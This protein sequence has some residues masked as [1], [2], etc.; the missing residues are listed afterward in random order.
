[1]PTRRI[2]DPRW[3]GADPAHTCRDPDHNPPDMVCWEPG[4]YEHTCGRCGMSRTFT[5]ERGHSMVHV[6]RVEVA[7]ADPDRWIA[8]M[9]DELVKRG[10]GWSR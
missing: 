1:M 4:T 9:A 3:K 5:V 6:E 2:D 8:D 10:M 7:S